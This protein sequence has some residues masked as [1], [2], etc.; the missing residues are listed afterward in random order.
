[1]GCLVR[2]KR[3][4]PLVGIQR[5]HVELY[6]RQLGEQ[7]LRDSS[8]VTMMHAVRGYVRFVRI[9]APIGSDPAMY[10][11][12]PKVH[13]DESR[14]RGLDR[15]ELIRVPQVA[16]TLTV[17]HGARGSGDLQ[18]VSGPLALFGAVAGE[19]GGLGARSRRREEV[20]MS[21]GIRQAPH[22]VRRDVSEQPTHLRMRQ[23]LLV[24]GIVYAV[25]Y[26]VVNDAI[27]A[28]LYAGYSRMS[29]AVSELSAT[30]APSRPFLTAVGPFFALLQIGFGVGVWESAHGKRPIR[31]AGA[32]LVGHG[33]MS[34]LWILAPMSQRE[35]IAAGGAT[36]ADT[37]HL[38]LAAGTGLFVAAYVAIFAI[39]F[40]WFFRVYSVLTL[41]GA[42]VFGRL[43]AQVDQLEAGDPTP[44]MGLLERIGIGAWLLWLGVAAVVL[45]RRNGVHN[46]AAAHT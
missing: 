14:T 20:T 29:Q 19:E 26:P 31:I 25:L 34:L 18:P 9:D 22:G 44:Y 41:A 17:H 35:V 4:D 16:R 5:A 46:L 2:G 7:P 8:V 43:S 1:M 21:G 36:P 23:A 10:A 40:G 13:R 28:A 12:L 30:G 32:L 37:M 38:L 33:A 45:L 6:I 11:R 3:V 27:A 15:L 39:A 24:C 42:L